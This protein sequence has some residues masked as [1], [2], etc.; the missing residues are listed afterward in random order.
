LFSSHFNEHYH[1]IHGARQES[2]HVFLAMGLRALPPAAQPLHIFEMGFGTGLNALLTALEDLARP[3]HYHGIEAYPLAE[4]QWRALD[5]CASLAH[6]DCA[7]LFRRMHEAPWGAA[8]ALTPQ[9]TLHKEAL[10]LQS[11]QPESRFDLVYWDAFA[12]TA[13]PELWTADVFREVFAWMKPG[14][15]WVTYSAKGA[16]RRALQSVGLEVERLPGPPGKREMLR[17]RKP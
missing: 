2:E 5:Y 6:P 14:G 16:V 17:A 10:P 3:V 13:Q 9:F 15:I 11:Y 8:L 12:P 4:E 7:A 1:S